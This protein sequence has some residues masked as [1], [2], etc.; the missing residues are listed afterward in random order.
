MVQK[1]ILQR[2]KRPYNNRRLN[3]W[4]KERNC[5]RDKR[6]NKQCKKEDNKAMQEVGKK[7]PRDYK[8]LFYVR[9]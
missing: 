7:K 6:S 5:E 3:E 1:K 8:K 4:V 9:L 2:K